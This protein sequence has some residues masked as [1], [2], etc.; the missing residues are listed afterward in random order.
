MA[1]YPDIQR[2]VQH[3]IE[4]AIGDRMPRSNDRQRMRFTEATLCEVQ[5]FASL[6]GT[7]PRR[8][9]EE[10]EVRG[11]YIEENSTAFVNMYGVHRDA[12]IWP[13][14]DRFDPVA[15]FLSS[16]KRNDAEK[17]ELWEEPRQLTRTEYLIPFGIG[18]RECLG[19]SLVRQELF[20]FF[21]RL[22]H[23][24]TIVA[25]NGDA[26]QLPPDYT[27]ENSPVFRMPPFYKLQFITR[28]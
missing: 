15:N 10:C 3:E 25:P 16:D 24:F 22:L 23:K 11:Y 5:R 27:A 20:I 21:V 6:I 14:P 19:E 12:A 18:K 28:N 9:I 13:A 4:G 1:R 2:R 7:I 8:T 26:A 17:L